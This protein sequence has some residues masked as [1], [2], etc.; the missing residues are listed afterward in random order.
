MGDMEEYLRWIK[1]ISVA[2]LAYLAYL[3]SWF[4]PAI[5]S[6]PVPTDVKN[7]KVV[8]NFDMPK[9]AED[10]VHRIGRTGRAGAKGIAYSFFTAADARL[11][12]AI[13]GI[14]SEAQQ[15]VP[16]QL[17]QFAAVTSGHS[18]HHGRLSM[19]HIVRHG[20]MHVNQSCDAM[21]TWKGGL[22]GSTKCPPDMGCMPPCS[23]AW[24]FAWTWRDGP[25]WSKRAA[26]RATSVLSCPVH[27]WNVHHSSSSSWHHRWQR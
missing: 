12:K 1:C 14:L 20:C 7:V 26:S 9:T 3:G 2:Y 8:I 4:K 19:M 16:P 17:A 22:S 23:A 11:S 24:T 18:S 21:C 13:I 15:V 5:F 27:K 25:H 6:W 10:Y